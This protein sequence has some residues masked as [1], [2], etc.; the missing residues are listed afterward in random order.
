MEH[1]VVEDTVL[2][3]E[4]SLKVSNVLCNIKYIF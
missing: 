1:S 4:N 3:N 2:E